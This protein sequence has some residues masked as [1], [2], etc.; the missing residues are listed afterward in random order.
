MTDLNGMSVFVAVAET[1][2]LTAAGKKLELP[3]STV[4]RRL[5]AYESTLGATLFRRATRSISLTD[6]GKKHFDRVRFLIHEAD[7][8]INELSEQSLQPTGLIRISASLGIGERLLA[9]LVWEFLNS[10][11]NVRIEMVLTDKVI[12]LVAEGVD[13]TIRM[14]S[15]ND[16]EL[17]AKH[18][19]N[20]RRILVVAPS[21]LAD[22]FVPATVAQLRQLP[23]IVMSPSQ[24]VWQF[25]NGE[26]VRVNWRVAAGSMPVLVEACLQGQGV[27]LLPEQIVRPHVVA[28]T[29]V[30]LL[31]HVPLPEVPI[32]I[33]YPR[34]KHKTAAARAFLQALRHLKV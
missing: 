10:H 20:G 11:P 4:S 6:A 26:S 15:L 27:A 34:L 25:A 30:Q 28:G 24:S 19:G 2:S 16:S 9:P 3:K 21:I 17:M 12:D 32:T 22:Y 23:T 5:Q 13:F 18:L 33:V 29:L 14:G 8:A 7:E 1:G 31:P